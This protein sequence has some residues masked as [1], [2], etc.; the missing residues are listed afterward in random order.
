MSSLI[1]RLQSWLRSIGKRDQLDAEMDE[2]LRF[3]LE[4]RA[5][6]SRQH[7]HDA[8]GSRPAAPVSNSAA[9]QR[10]RQTC[11][12]PSASAG[13]TSSGPTSATLPASCARA[14]G[15]TAIAVISLALAIGANTTIF[16]VANE[17]LFMRLGVPHPEQLRL[18][19]MRGDEHV[20]VHS[21]WGDWDPDPTGGVTF[22]TFSYPV[23]QQL[24]KQNRVLAPIF[25]FKN[26]LRVN[27]T[28]NGSAQ[29]GD[30]ELVSGNYYQQLQVKPALGRAILP[31]DDAVPGSGA[32]VVISDGFWNRNFSR[33]PDAIGK[34][35]SVNMTPVTI[36]G[37]NPPRFT[38]AKSVQRSPRSLHAAF[39][40]HACQGR[41]GSLRLLSLDFST[42]VGAID[43]AHQSRCSCTAGAGCLERRARIGDPGNHDCEERRYSSTPL[44]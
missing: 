42:L 38:G 8:T 44:S 30:L 3:H 20:V 11:A 36:I 33:S 29:D 1:A 7:R 6:R 27:I 4:A 26:N 23:Y 9:P 31:A 14:P 19:T 21:S 18:L 35:I 16:S 32:V 37:V 10:T 13:G 28:V 12:T 17:L 43:V 39:D 24:Q 15:F 2:E 40:D 34:V 25:A 5:A 22:N 41:H